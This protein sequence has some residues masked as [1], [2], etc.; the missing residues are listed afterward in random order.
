MKNIILGVESEFSISRR[1]SIYFSL[2]IPYQDESLSI[3]LR[4]V[5]R[6]NQ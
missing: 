2:F 6:N 1:K 4:D 3:N 5:C